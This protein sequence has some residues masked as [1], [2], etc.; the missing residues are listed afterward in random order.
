MAA[1]RKNLVPYLDVFSNIELPMMA[2]ELSGK[3]RKLKVKELIEFLNLDSI[4]TRLPENISGGE[5]QI[6]AI[7]VALA[8]Q[9][10]LLLADEPT[11]EL[12]DETSDMV[13]E[14]MRYV[15]KNFGTTVVIVTMIL[16]LKTMLIGLLG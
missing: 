2:S 16:K 5:Q 4:S 13:L 8:N 9:P 1:N 7:A 12:D 15:N 3:E 10:P 11:G 14:K 6:A